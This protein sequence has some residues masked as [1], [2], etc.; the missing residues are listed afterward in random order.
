M[1]PFE[2]LRLLNLNINTQNSKMIVHG[3]YDSI[4]D[5]RKPVTAE[6]KKKALK[7]ARRFRK[8]AEKRGL[9]RFWTFTFYWWLS[10]KERMEKWNAFKTALRYYYPHIEYLG[11]KEIHPGHGLNFGQIH[12]HLLLSEYVPWELVQ[13][14]WEQCGAGKVVY[15]KKVTSVKIVGYVCKYM[16]K[17]LE[18]NCV[19]RPVVSSREFCLH[20]S[21]F[22]KWAEKLASWGDTAMIKWI[23]DN[24]D[25]GEYH[26]NAGLRKRRNIANLYCIGVSIGL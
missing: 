21:D 26:C 5:E 9:V 17:D 8:V 22:L 11:V 19:N 3:I 15:V 6:Q 2:R 24:V 12:L 4:L 18:Y 23:L 14:L 10:H 20:T 1:T 7:I 25:F 16:Y 13:K